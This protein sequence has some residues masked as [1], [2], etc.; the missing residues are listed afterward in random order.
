MIWLL[1]SAG[2]SALMKISPVRMLPPLGSPYKDQINHGNN[3]G[4]CFGFLSQNV[5]NLRPGLVWRSLQ[6]QGKHQDQVP[7][8][9]G[10]VVAALPWMNQFNF[11]FDSEMPKHLFTKAAHTWACVCCKTATDLT[12]ASISS[13]VGSYLGKQYI[14][15]IWSKSLPTSSS[16][17]FKL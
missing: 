5:S 14:K 16:H 6:W 13:L 17:R 4:V 9:K 2:L 7:D 1:Q 12:L 11:E 3:Y 10:S 15:R 8:Q